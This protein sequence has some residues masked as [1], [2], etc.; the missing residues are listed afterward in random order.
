M[1]DVKPTPAQARFLREHD[2]DGY[3]PGYLSG[4]GRPAY[5]FVGRVRDAGFIEIIDGKH[6][7]WPYLWAGTKLTEAGRKAIEL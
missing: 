6:T 4:R 2:A 3:R 1:G 5:D 7:G